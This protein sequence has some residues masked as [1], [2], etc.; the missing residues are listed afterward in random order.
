M[1][2]EL[3]FIERIAQLFGRGAKLSEE[4][5]K[6]LSEGEKAWESA[7]RGGK[8]VGE[9]AKGAKIVKLAG[10]GTRALKIGA[11]GG[12]ASFFGFEWL[13]NGGLVRAVGGTLGINNTA[14]SILVVIVAL[15]V[16]AVLIFGLYKHV[17]NGTT[18][19]ARTS[20]TRAGNGNTRGKSSGPKNKRRRS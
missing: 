20:S 8:V 17:T 12:L 6:V 3:T 14:A 7:I 4:G 9:T 15:G 10:E 13:T 11:V 18:V 19:K 16:V 1:A 2:G 5:G